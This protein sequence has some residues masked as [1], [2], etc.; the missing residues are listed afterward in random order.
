MIQSCVI[1]IQRAGSFKVP[2]RS[3]SSSGGLGVTLGGNSADSS[4]RLPARGRYCTLILSNHEAR[5]HVNDQ[6]SITS[7]F[8]SLS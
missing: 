2:G 4:V 6:A 8:V 1:R 5:R 3:S 7:I